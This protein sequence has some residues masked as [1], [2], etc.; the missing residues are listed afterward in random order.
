M[1]QEEFDFT[2]A[3]GKI[4]LPCDIAVMEYAMCLLRR[5]ASAELE[6]AFLSTM[7]MSCHCASHMAPIVGARQQI[8]V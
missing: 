7:A 2:G 5:G 4:T 6:Q 1:P 3:D 8:V